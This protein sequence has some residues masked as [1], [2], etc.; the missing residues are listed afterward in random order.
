[1][2]QSSKKFKGL[3]IL[4]KKAKTDL[5]EEKR[6]SVA[7]SKAAD[8]AKELVQTNNKKRAHAAL[9]KARTGL[10]ARAKMRCQSRTSLARRTS[11]PAMVAP[12]FPPAA[13][14]V[15]AEKEAAE[16]ED[17]NE[18]EEGNGDGNEE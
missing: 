13:P 9:E 12:L 4:A 8:E 1:M 10:A 3:Q 16:K 6:G 17:T 5:D 7:S 15:G 18:D 2:P 14:I 11:D